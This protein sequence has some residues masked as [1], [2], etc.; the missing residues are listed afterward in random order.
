MTVRITGMASGMDVDKMVQELMKARRMKYDNMVKDRTKVEW[1][2]EDYRSLTAK[3]VDFRNNKLSNYSLSGAINA[4]TTK[5]TGDTNALTV[6][7]TSSSATGS[8]NVEVI[9]VAKADTFVYG[10][11]QGTS[12]FSNGT[13]ISINGQSIALGTGDNMKTLADKINAD[14]VKYKATATYNNGTLSIKATT[15]G[16]GKLTVTGFDTTDTEDPPGSGTI[17]AATV[18][19]DVTTYKGSDATIKVD[20]VEFKQSNNDFTVNGVSFRVN[21][22][23]T[24][25]ATLTSTKD[26]DKI[27]NTIKSF[28]ADYNALIDAINPKLVEKKNYKFS[29]LTDDQKKEMKDKEIEQW[30]EKARSGSLAHDN[31]LGKLVAD[32]RLAATS[33]IEG[34][35]DPTPADPNKKLSIGITSGSYT[36]KGKLYLDE[37]KL[38]AV[39]NSDPNKVVQLFTAPGT[40]DAGGKLDT[41]ASNKAVGVFT[42]MSSSAMETLKGLSSKAGTSMYSTDTKTAFLENSLLSTQVR[43]MKKREDLELDK[44][45]SLENH[46]YKIFASMETSINRFNT[47]SSSLFSM[48]K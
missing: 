14:P 16:A 2:Q 4:Q 47:Q 32:L 31:T 28:V 11:K 41:S 44:L 6:T 42:R 20:G 25:A 12:E 43:L 24:T 29:P 15:T 7:A 46:Y 17:R 33:L 35:A 23:T 18:S 48:G 8:L 30:E 39:L 45:S 36:E 5:V 38:R 34:V 26:N 22:K 1:Q 21:A 37:D 40:V 3:I 10:F 9:D 13:T 19:A 27:V